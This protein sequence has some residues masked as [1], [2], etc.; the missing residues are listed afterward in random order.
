MLHLHIC[1]HA[2]PTPRYSLVVHAICVGAGATCADPRCANPN[3]CQADEVAS[4]VGS[5][6]CRDG[7]GTLA[8]SRAPRAVVGSTVV[9]LATVAILAQ[10]CAATGVIA[11]SRQKM[12][13]NPTDESEEA[14]DTKS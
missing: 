9:G 6:G 12:Q 5:S 4:C 8:L 10:L 13:A 3:D 2:V 7:E 1:I 14:A 11:E